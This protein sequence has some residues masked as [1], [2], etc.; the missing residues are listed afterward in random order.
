MRYHW[1]L[2]YKYEK[3]IIDPDPV[4][5]EQR[6]RE[7]KQGGPNESDID[8]ESGQ[9]GEQQY[10]RDNNDNNDNNDDEKELQQ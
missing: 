3:Y 1:A 10:E 8:I 7:K 5:V 4:Y 9:H 2:F 6:E